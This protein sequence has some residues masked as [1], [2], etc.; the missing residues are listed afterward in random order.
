MATLKD[1]GAFT[2]CLRWN[3]WDGKRPF[4]VNKLRR[5]VKIS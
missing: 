1:M 4:E 3:R 2:R 5:G